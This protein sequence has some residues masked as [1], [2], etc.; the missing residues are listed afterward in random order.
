[1]TFWIWFEWQVTA[2]P[3]STLEDDEGTFRMNDATLKLWQSMP[4]RAQGFAMILDIMLE[5]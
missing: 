4:P 1:M 3:Y 2:E 5:D